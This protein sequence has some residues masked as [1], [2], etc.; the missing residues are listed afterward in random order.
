MLTFITV[1][2]VQWFKSWDPATASLYFRVP[3]VTDK[4]LPLEIDLAEIFTLTPDFTWCQTTVIGLTSAAFDET[5][6]AASS[7]AKTHL[8]VQPTLRL[9]D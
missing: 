7:A 6:P 3:R 5:M 8:K 1:N 9:D 4:I 2:E